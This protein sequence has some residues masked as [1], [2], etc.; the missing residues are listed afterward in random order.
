MIN[1]INGKRQ[2]IDYS[3]YGT[4]LEST[5]LKFAKKTSGALW[6]NRG[7][8]QIEIMSQIPI[9]FQYLKKLIRLK[10]YV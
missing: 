7:E 10:N 8:L 1:V 2:N 6:C 3:V 5:T 4:P 9:I